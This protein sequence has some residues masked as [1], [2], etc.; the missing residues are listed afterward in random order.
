MKSTLVRPVDW[1]LASQLLHSWLHGPLNT[2][3]TSCRDTQLRSPE[4]FLICPAGN[5][6][7][8]R[9]TSKT[10]VFPE[11]VPSLRFSAGLVAAAGL[12]QATADQIAD[13]QQGDQE[14]ALIGAEPLTVGTDVD[15]PGGD[16]DTEDRKQID[17]QFGGLK[18]WLG[19]PGM[20]ALVIPVCDSPSGVIGASYRPG[21]TAGA[22]PRHGGAAGDNCVVRAAGGHGCSFWRRGDGIDRDTGANSPVPP[23]YFGY[24]PASCDL[25]HRANNK[26]S[27][28]KKTSPFCEGQIRDRTRLGRMPQRR[29][30]TRRTVRRSGLARTGQ[31]D[32]AR[33]SQHD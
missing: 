33:N 24:A 29:R 28:A 12:G 6:E 23:A 25:H 21:G 8:L 17:N 20:T 2:L 27:A 19:F 32:L 18:G 16:Q 14:P 10:Q 4:T 15:H 5:G 26:E 31:S 30:G 3:Q 9:T 11:L 1:A 22:S 7:H 13:R